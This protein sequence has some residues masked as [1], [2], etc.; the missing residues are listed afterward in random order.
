MQTYEADAKRELW[1][2]G[3][4]AVAHG[5]SA[6]QVYVLLQR[7]ALSGVRLGRRTLVTDS[8]RNEWLG[9]LPRFQSGSSPFCVTQAAA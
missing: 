4:F 1:S 6:R 3:E 5:I 7:G 8:S 2:I 9:T